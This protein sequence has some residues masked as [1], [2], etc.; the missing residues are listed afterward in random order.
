M[1]KEAAEEEGLQE[2]ASM[3]TP[4]NFDNGFARLVV[5]VPVPGGSVPRNA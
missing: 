3:T 5:D 2:T 4:F 1:E